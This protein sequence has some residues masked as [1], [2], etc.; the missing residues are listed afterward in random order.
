M[1]KIRVG[2]KVKFK[3]LN[4]KE[5]KRNFLDPFYDYDDYLKDFEATWFKSF[6]GRVKSVK[7]G[8]FNIIVTF[9]K[10]NYFFEESINDFE[11]EVIN[12]LRYKLNLLKDFK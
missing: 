3:R 10:E 12:S 2:S 7:G 5:F 9:K 1:E 8:Y 4:E 6:V 11:L